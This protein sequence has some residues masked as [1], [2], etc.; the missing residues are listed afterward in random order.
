MTEFIIMNKQ[1]QQQKQQHHV[2]NV[3]IQ[4]QHHVVHQHPQTLHGTSNQGQTGNQPSLPPLEPI[5]NKLPLQQTPP[6][7][8]QPPQRKV[9]ANLQLQAYHHKQIQD[10]YHSSR[11]QIPSK[12]TPPPPQNSQPNHRNDQIPVQGHAHSQTDQNRIQ[13]HGNS[14]PPRHQIDNNSQARQERPVAPQPPPT[15][16]ETPQTQRPP[17]VLPQP[18]KL[19][20][21]KPSPSQQSHQRPP[22][23]SQHIPS[24]TSRER[25]MFPKHPQL[26]KQ[27]QNKGQMR[28]PTQGKAKNNPAGKNVVISQPVCTTVI[29]CPYCNVPTWGQK[30]YE[31]HIRQNHAE[32]ALE[33]SKLKKSLNLM[34]YKLMKVLVKENIRYQ[35]WTIPPK[36]T[37]N[38]K[39]YNKTQTSNSN[40]STSEIMKLLDHTTL[41]QTRLD[42]DSRPHNGV[43]DT[44]TSQDVM[45]EVIAKIMVPNSAPKNVASPELTT[46]PA[47]P[48][49]LPIPKKSPGLEVTKE[50]SSLRMLRPWDDGKR[51]SNQQNECQSPVNN[52]S[53]AM[54]IPL[55]KRRLMFYQEQSEK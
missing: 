35:S 48:K 34:P 1:H 28:P 2:K 4:N 26:Q 10:Q 55:K 42:N 18:P 53:N 11:H 15:A 19:H 21:Q 50:K 47:M 16:K 24:H 36:M 43:V 3:A 52:E 22:V 31:S 41:E 45:E 6:P 8:N 23:L 51:K 32:Q 17:N 12:Q 25:P 30:E 37:Y 9:H 49:L 40:S 27:S 14:Q 7:N 38:Y 39:S 54:P 20:Q 44:L 46:L 33:P 5:N 29:I 13:A